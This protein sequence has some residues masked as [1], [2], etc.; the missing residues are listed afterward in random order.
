M[1]LFALPPL[2]SSLM[3]SLRLAASTI[4]RLFSIASRKHTTSGFFPSHFLESVG[5]FMG[6]YAAVVL[7]V[8]VVLIF[9]VVFVTDTVGYLP[10]ALPDRRAKEDD[11]V[12]VE[13]GF[14]VDDW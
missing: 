7:L 11:V 3:Y 2:C 5:G 14:N 9:V 6:S 1:S 12:R 4:S 13:D 10:D 8:V